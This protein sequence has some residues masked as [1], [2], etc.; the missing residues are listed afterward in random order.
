MPSRAMLMFA[1]K[2]ARLSGRSWTFMLEALAFVAGDTPDG[3][4]ELPQDLALPRVEHLLGCMGLPVLQEAH[5]LASGGEQLV[6][7][8]GNVG[9]LPSY[10]DCVHSL[11][12]LAG[13]W[14]WAR[15]R[16]ASTPAGPFT[17]PT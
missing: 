3:A 17:L 10:T 9:G 2:P 8:A 12:P 16:G 6:P 7:C 13:C 15:S 5:G 1:R 4:P 14:L 11:P